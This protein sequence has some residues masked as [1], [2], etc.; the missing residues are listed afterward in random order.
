MQNLTEL[1]FNSTSPKT[2]VIVKVCVVIPFFCFFLSFIALMLHTFAS[3]RHFLDTSRYVLFAH[4]LINDTVQLMISVPLFLCAI[5][6]A[7][8]PRVLCVII[9]TLSTSTFQNTNLILAAMSLERYVAIFYPLQPP[10][11]WRSDRIW[12]INLCLWLFSFTFSVTEFC[13]RKQD[14]ALNILPTPVLC[15]NTVINSSPVQA[16]FRAA[17]SVFFFSVVAVIILFTYLRI[18]LE[19][20]KLRQDRASVSKAL[21]TV[22]LHGFQLLLCMLAF[23]HPF[24]ETLFVL[25]TTW[26]TEDVAF[27]NYFCF[28]LVPRF[29]SPLIY[30][31]RDQSLRKHIGKTFICGPKRRVKPRLRC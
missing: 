29:L 16:V 14:P 9:L 27:F 23:T 24:T 31:F 18:L 8:F 19:T 15:I 13:I 26:L 12:A 11:F 28:I 17:M 21:H 1:P 20:R 2:S 22:L 6:R 30:G 10:A 5:G 4:M 25:H 7:R 3:H